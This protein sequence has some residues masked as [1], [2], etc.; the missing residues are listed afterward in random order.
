M[1]TVKSEAD[2]VKMRKA[3]AVTGQTLKMI[4]EF[5]KP[6]VTTEE[7]D[8]IIMEEVDERGYAVENGNST[9]DNF[10]EMSSKAL[11][12]VFNSSSVN[13]ACLPCTTLPFNRW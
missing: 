6:G 2:L 13:V 11:F 7:L 10:I 8:A 12:N 9:L 3:C 4:E 5:I 1:I